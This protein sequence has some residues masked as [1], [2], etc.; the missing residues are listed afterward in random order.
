M[1]EKMSDNAWPVPTAR[2]ADRFRRCTA[3]GRTWPGRK[4]LRVE[5]KVSCDRVVE[6]GRDLRCCIAPRRF[7]SD[8]RH[9]SS[10][11]SCLRFR[12]FRQPRRAR[13]QHGWTC[14]FL[15]RTR[16]GNSQRAH[17]LHEDG[18]LFD[19]VKKKLRSHARERRPR[20][21]RFPVISRL[22]EDVV[23]HALCV[24][25]PGI[26][27]VFVLDGPRSVDRHRR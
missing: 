8:G 11:A 15:R 23:P 10:V 7:R 20:P 3:R 17:M 22:A 26:L 12:R 6:H 18:E 27:R 16:R 13:R 4:W 1:D 14:A 19:D 25:Q 9:A 5:H 24:R 2:A 21:L